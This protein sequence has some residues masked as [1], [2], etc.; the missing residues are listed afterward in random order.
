MDATRA[1]DSLI[2]RGASNFER[3]LRRTLKVRALSIKVVYPLESIV[4]TLLPPLLATIR[5]EHEAFEYLED[6]VVAKV[7]WNNDPSG[8]ASHC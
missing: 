1:L 6:I 2:S 8:T 5:S 3:N 7:K 4:K